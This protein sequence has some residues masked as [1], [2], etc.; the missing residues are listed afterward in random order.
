MLF[1]APEAPGD[2]PGA[3]SADVYGDG[4]LGDEQ[5]LIEH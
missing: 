5:R 3:V 2:E 4:L 1:S